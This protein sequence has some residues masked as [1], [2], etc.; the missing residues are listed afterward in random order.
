MNPLSALFG[1]AVRLRNT[2]YD[3]GWKRTHK[4]SWPVISVGNLN[5]GGSGK[6][7]F[8]IA[9]G[10]LLRKRQ[11]AFDVLSRGYGR[12]DAAIRLVDEQGDAALF[13]DEPILISGKLGIPVIVGAD[14]VAA[15]AFAEKM[16]QDVRPAHGK[17][18][19]HLLDDGFQHRRLHREVDIVLLTASDIDDQ[20]L[21]AG[22]LREPL[23]SISRAKV[24]AAPEDLDLTSP[25]IARCIANKPVWRFRREFSIPDGIPGRVLALCGIAHPDR[26][27]ADIRQ[28]GMEIAREM[29]SPDHHLFSEREVK[30]IIVECRSAAAGGILTTEKDLVRLRPFMK[31]F[32]EE[33]LPLLAATLTINI[34]DGEVALDALLQN[35]WA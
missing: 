5:V 8:L 12:R 1:G 3:R 23:S 28:A 19:L 31:R 27:F 25:H 13:G 29:R 34:I 35:L 33:L 15:G 30:R 6:T 10:E 14:R 7:P 32:E 4:L 24:I 9:L 17:G 26:F 21:P 20:L 2:A 11:A 22:R 16:F 18:W